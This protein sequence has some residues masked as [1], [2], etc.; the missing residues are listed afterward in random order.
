MNTIA[1]AVVKY[2]NED[3]SPTTL[4]PYQTVLQIPITKDEKDMIIKTQIDDNNNTTDLATLIDSLSIDTT[5]NTIYASISIT[6]AL[7]TINDISFN[8][9][10]KQI[11]QQRLHFKL[12]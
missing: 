5:N 7:I 3:I 6:P 2:F 1:T 4:A 9:I 8:Q 12:F 10:T 11:Q